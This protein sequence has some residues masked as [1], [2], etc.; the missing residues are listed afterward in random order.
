[1]IEIKKDIVLTVDGE[2]VQVLSAICEIA[3][4]EMRKVKSDSVL[5]SDTGYW[6]GKKLSIMEDFVNKIFDNT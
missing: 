6:N 2:D 1:M 5:G 4:V 3:R